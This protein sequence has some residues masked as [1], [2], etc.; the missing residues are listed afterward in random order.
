MSINQMGLFPYIEEDKFGFINV[1]GKVVV[2]AQTYDETYPYSEG[3]ALVR[4]KDRYGYV[5]H[6]GALVIPV[7]FSIANDFSCCG[8][9]SVAKDSFWGFVDRQGREVLRGG[10]SVFHNR[11]SEGLLPLENDYGRWGVTD[12]RGRLVLDYQFDFIGGDF[13][14]GMV[15]AKSN[16]KW[17][18]I[19]FNGRWVIEPVYKSLRSLSQGRFWFTNE[20]GE[21]GLLSLD[22][23]EFP[24]PGVRHI[25]PFNDGISV[26]ALADH[27]S[28]LIDLYGKVVFDPRSLAEKA[29]VPE[30]FSEGLIGIETERETIFL[31]RSFKEQFRLPGVELESEFAMGLARIRFDEAPGGWGY[32]NR[33]GEIVW[34]CS[35][36]YEFSL[37]ELIKKEVGYHWLPMVDRYED[38]NEYHRVSITREEWKARCHVRY[39]LKIVADN[40]GLLE[41][42]RWFKSMAHMGGVG[43]SLQSSVGRRFELPELM[44]DFIDEDLP[45]DRDE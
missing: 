25:S 12:S 21:G 35:G 42:S 44:V 33:S 26:A 15:T 29:T 23:D 6:T 3:M 30:S 32:V 16:D 45:H 20:K 19:D 22:G 41:L 13:C 36:H 11:F 18:A 28:Y 27:R 9:A 40:N 10:L 14:D 2:P 5:D 37:S 39:D 8:L 17:G 34:R 43:D 38:L 24:I 31:N 1:N 4:V 7:V